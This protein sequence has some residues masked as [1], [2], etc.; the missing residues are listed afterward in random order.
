MG[1]RSEKC[2]SEHNRTGKVR[3]R[4]IVYLSRMVFISENGWDGVGY[5]I[6]RGMERSK[7]IALNSLGRHSN[8]SSL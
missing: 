5:A 7:E 1:I 6:L 3:E 8:I 4:Y 2:R